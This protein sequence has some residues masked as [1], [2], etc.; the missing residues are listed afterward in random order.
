MSGPLLASSVSSY[1]CDPDRR[2][3]ETLLVPVQR[4][5]RACSMGTPGMR[6]TRQRQIGRLW[7]RVAHVPQPLMGRHKGLHAA[8]SIDAV[9]SGRAPQHHLHDPQHCLGHLQVCLVAGLME[10]N[11]GPVGETTRVGSWEVQRSVAAWVIQSVV[12]TCCLPR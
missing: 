10:S 3:P 8:P 6:A 9:V 1:R 7:L 4:T 12:P 2:T 5:Q 11:K